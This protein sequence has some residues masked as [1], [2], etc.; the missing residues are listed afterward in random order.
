MSDLALSIVLG[1]SARC[2]DRLSSVL[3][4]LIVRSAAYSG[5]LQLGDSLVARDVTTKNIADELELSEGAGRIYAEHSL[6]LMF[7]LGFSSIWLRSR[8]LHRGEQPQRQALCGRDFRISASAHSSIEPTRSRNLRSET[9]ARCSSGSSLMSGWMRRLLAKSI[10]TAGSSRGTRQSDEA[11]Q[12]RCCNPM[13][14]NCFVATAR[15]E[16]GRLSAPYGSQ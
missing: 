8:S 4:M 16:T 6:T 9:A 2:C 5:R 10:T 14:L 7:R 12:G 11:I 1:I 13:I 3:L 15:R